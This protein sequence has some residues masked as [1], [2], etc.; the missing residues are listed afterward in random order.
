MPQ[1]LYLVTEDWFFVSH[2]LPMAHAAAAARFDV[3]VAT[4]VGDR[5]AAIRAA[6]FRLI[7]ID[8][9]RQSMGM[10]KVLR[11]I[12][13]T[14]TVIRDEKPDIVHCI[15]LRC[16]V[17]GGIA[18]RLAQ[19]RGL[20][21]APT[22]LGHL[23]LQQGLLAF[24]ARSI[25]RIIVG[26]WLR[27]RHTRYIF[28]NRDDPSEF[29]LGADDPDVTIV[30]AAGGDP[31]AF[32][33]YPEPAAPPVRIAVVAR[34]IRP[35]G[36]IEA[37]EAVRRARTLG[38]VVELDLFGEPDLS[39]PA[40]LTEAELRQS[41]AGPGVTWH[42]RATDVPGVWRDHHIALFLSYYREGLPRTLVEAAACGRPIVTTDVTGCREVVRDGIE[43]VIVPPHDIDAAGR[44]LAALAGDAALRTKMGTAANARYRE[45][46]T[47][48]IV[49]SQVMKVYRSLLEPT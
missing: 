3:V 40:T 8:S 29:E 24:V 19:A 22:G 35:K 11:Y 4:H 42:G 23:W 1:I 7:E 43:G 16:V 9:E 46:F 12:A 36:I 15:A 25:V 39:N 38:A 26:S 10:L 20:V 32:P 28:E 47:E 48:E 17:L 31:N 34:M 2:F 14:F 13:R 44:A 45:R 30:G 18:A 6:G 27:G 21:L 33:M 5:A 37:I 41:A 49:M